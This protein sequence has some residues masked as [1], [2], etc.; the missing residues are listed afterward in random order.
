MA[1]MISPMMVPLIILATGM[2][3]FYAPLGNWL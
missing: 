1:I 2:F 3:F